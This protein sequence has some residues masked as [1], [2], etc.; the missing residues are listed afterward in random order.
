[1]AIGVNEEAPNSAFS[2]IIPEKDIESHRDDL[3]K[4]GHS[5]RAQNRTSACRELISVILC[6]KNK[7]DKERTSQGAGRS[8]A[9]TVTAPAD[10]LVQLE[11]SGRNRDKNTMFELCLRKLISELGLSVMSL[12]E[13]RRVEGLS[14]CP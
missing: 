3:Y 2:S 5:G 9:S 11:R 1:M 10:I 7:I 14:T 4:V 6:Q 12:P 8:S 13:R